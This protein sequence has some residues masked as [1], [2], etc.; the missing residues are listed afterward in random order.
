MGMVPFY[1]GSCWVAVSFLATSGFLDR[2]QEEIGRWLDKRVNYEALVTYK[3]VLCRRTLLRSQVRSTRFL[4]A[5]PEAIC[6]FE[7]QNQAIFSTTEGRVQPPL[8]F[9]LRSKVGF[10]Y[11]PH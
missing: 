2:R 7:D 8:T 4:S 1:K 11:S 9:S 3:E 6:W 5:I 10:L